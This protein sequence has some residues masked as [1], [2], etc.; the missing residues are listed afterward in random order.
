MTTESFR[1]K[2]I[3]GGVRRPQQHGIGRVCEHPGC[4][5]VLSRYNRRDLCGVHAP[6]GFPR[7]R[8]RVSKA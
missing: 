4:E 2:R 1:A 5:T 8:G 3:R 6:K 7:V